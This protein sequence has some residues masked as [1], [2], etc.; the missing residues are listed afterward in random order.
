MQKEL[1]KEAYWSNLN[2]EEQA[3]Q[4]KLAMDKQAREKSK[5]TRNMLIVGA[6][7]LVLIGGGLYLYKTKKAK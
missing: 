2:A 5:N 7:V 1:Q 4:L 3:F 6:V